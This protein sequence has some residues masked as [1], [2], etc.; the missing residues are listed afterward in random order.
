M[1]GHQNRLSGM[2]RHQLTK[3]FEQLESRG[4]HSPD[5]REAA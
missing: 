3:S 5:P 2:A 1:H 4:C